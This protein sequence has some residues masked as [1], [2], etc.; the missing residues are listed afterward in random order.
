VSFLAPGWCAS[1][2]T[3]SCWRT[4][5]LCCSAPTFSRWPRK[6][7]TSTAGRSLPVPQSAISST[8]SSPYRPQRRTD[9]QCRHQGD[10]QAAA[11]ATDRHV[12]SAPRPRRVVGH[13]PPEAEPAAATGV[14]IR[15]THRVDGAAATSAEQRAID[16]IAAQAGAPHVGLRRDRGRPGGNSD[17]VCPLFEHCGRLSPGPGQRRERTCRTEVLAVRRPVLLTQVFA[18]LARVRSPRRSPPG[19]P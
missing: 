3:R 13:W 5:G 8:R 19:C 4:R 6:A 7:S 12:G 11:A 9:A 17:T 2:T 14:G 15:G 18:L 1:T 16:E 10:G